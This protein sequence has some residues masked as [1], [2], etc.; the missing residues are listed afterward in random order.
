MSVENKTTAKTHTVT[1]K[2]SGTS[3]GER[4][5]DP[6]MPLSQFVTAAATEFGVRSFCVM[7]N[8]NQVGKD[9]KDTA[10]S[11]FAKIDIIAKDARG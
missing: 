1:L 3:V 10:I 6:D 7:G 2:V 8:G 5:V 4:K 9:K 11:E